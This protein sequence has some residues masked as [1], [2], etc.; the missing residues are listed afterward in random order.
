[1]RASIA[2]ALVALALPAAP[3]SAQM[4]HHGHA[5]EGAAVA[6]APQEAGQ[7]A[8]AA[9]AEIVAL[10]EADPA[11][12]WSRVDI[13]GLRE[14]LVDMDEVMLRSVAVVEEVPGGIAVELTGEDRTREAL[15]RMVPAHA[16]ELAKLR[17]F[18]AKG[19]ATPDGARL[20]VTGA[21]PATAARIRGLG[22]YGLMAT[23]SHH[24]AHHLAIARGLHPHPH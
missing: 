24:Q 8:F 2:V 11:T 16:G 12:D 4:A 21:D 13:A 14:H 10:L 3:A 9:V 1:M 15:Q 22:F 23:G 18:A 7:G 17:G 20:V 5:M 19:E 6:A